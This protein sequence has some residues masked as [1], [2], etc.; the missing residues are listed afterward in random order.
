MNRESVE[1]IEAIPFQPP[2]QALFELLQFVEDSHRDLQ[3]LCAFEFSTDELRGFGEC[4][5]TAAQLDRLLS[6]GAG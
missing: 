4:E 1:V 5:L 3:R 6:R 2:S